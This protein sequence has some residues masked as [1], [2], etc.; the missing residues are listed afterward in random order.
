[1][2]ATIHIAAPSLSL[3]KGLQAL[4]DDPNLPFVRPIPSATK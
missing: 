4:L 1:M 3:Q 2:T